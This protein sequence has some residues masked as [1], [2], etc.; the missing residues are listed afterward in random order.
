MLT[1]VCGWGSV[2]VCCELLLESSEL[3]FIHSLTSVM[4]RL[5][6]HK[7]EICFIEVGELR[8]YLQVLRH[9]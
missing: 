6:S 3:R 2:W 4:K 9:C 8:L 5:P 1:S 7:A